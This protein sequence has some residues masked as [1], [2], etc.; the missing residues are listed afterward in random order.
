MANFLRAIFILMLAALIGAA[1]SQ[2]SYAAQ[3]RVAPRGTSAFDGSWSVLMQTTRGNCPAAVR[4]G[5]Q[6][7]GGRLTAEDQNYGL[8]GRVARSGAVWVSVSAA[9]QTGGA[10]GHLSRGAGRGHW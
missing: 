3:R 10:F 1:A 5:V 7:L 6:I 2:A 4:A 9:G 8:D